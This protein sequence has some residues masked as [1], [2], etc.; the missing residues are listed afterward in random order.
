MCLE[1]LLPGAINGDDDLIV[2]MEKRAWDV[3]NHVAMTKILRLYGL[4]SVFRYDL[5]AAT[6]KSEIHAGRPVVL[7]ILHKG[8][9][10]KPWGG[11]MIVAVGLDP[12]SD[13]VICHDPYGSLLDGYSG[14]ADSGK[15]I[16]YPWRELHARW[17]VEGPDSGWG[18][19]FLTSKTQ[20]TPNGHFLSCLTA[21]QPGSF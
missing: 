10:N 13:A 12:A 16:S 1:Y 9:T 21:P 11:H 7:G 18:R 8:D 3:T 20:E 15:F 2:E 6:L 14:A 4:E 19:I 5:T 17:L